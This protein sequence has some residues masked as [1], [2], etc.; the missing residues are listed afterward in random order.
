M[1]VI[2]KNN[3]ILYEIQK[4]KFYGFN[5]YVETKDDCNQILDRI[6]QEFSDA[7]HVCYAYIL[8][9]F[10][11]IQ[12]YSDDGEPTGT[13]GLPILS[14]LL[15]YELTNVLVVVVRYFGGIKLG[16][17]GLLRSYTKTVTNLIDQCELIDYRKFYYYEISFDY[18]SNKTIDYWLNGLNVEVLEKH[19]NME[20]TYKIKCDTEIM[21]HSLLRNFKKVDSN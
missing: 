9:E 10:Q 4:S 18:S 5:F 6:R 12:K 11:S 19:Y 8:N 1:K 2:F 13:A 16:T 17:G 14:Q 20:I 7:T 21:P 3:S 15:R